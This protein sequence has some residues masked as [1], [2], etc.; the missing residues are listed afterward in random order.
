MTAPF[1]AAIPPRYAGISKAGHNMTNTIPTPRS[2]VWSALATPP[3]LPRE[4]PR[5]KINK[6]FFYGFYPA[7][8]A[9]IALV[10]N[11]M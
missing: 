2:R 4:G 8:L 10:Q 9:F 11:L 1:A 7:Y 5:L 3:A 6:W